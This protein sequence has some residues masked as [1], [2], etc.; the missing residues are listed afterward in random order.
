MFFPTGLEGVTFDSHGCKLLGG[1]YLAAGETPRPTVILLHGIPGVEKNLDIAYALRDA[2]FNCLYFHYRGCWGSEGAYA[3]STLHEDVHAA[4]EW[5]LKQPSVDAARLALVGSSLGGYTALR[6]G[7]LDARFKVIVSLCPLL[8]P[9]NTNLG[10]ET[11]DDFASMLNGI[12]GAE[13]E[14]QWYALPPIPTFSAQ[15]ASRPI[16]LVTGDE[17]ALF[18][19]AHSASLRAALPHL[20]WHRFAEGDHSFSVCRPALVQTV[21]NWLAHNL[22]SLILNL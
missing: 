1:L 4:T 13:V 14:A 10:R 16:L 22:Y 3:L 19:P 12:A 7:A 21:V 8:E 15:L 6:A 17:D 11:F 5:V 20:Q 2:G 9:L 18:P